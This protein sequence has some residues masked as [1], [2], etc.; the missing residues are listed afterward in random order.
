MPGLA[1]LYEVDS[2]ENVARHP[3]GASGSMSD[4]RLFVNI[5]YA[6]IRK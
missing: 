4:K 1:H 6:K 5:I 2:R 3:L